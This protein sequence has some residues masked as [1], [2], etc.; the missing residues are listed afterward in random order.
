MSLKSATA[1]ALSIVVACGPSSPPSS[2]KDFVS[3]CFGKRFYAI[4]ASIFK[5]RGNCG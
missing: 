3:V 4:S 1:S 2:L 5:E